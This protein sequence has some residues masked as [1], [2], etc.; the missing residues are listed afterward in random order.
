MIKKISAIVLGLLLINPAYAT[1]FKTFIPAQSTA[2]TP[3]AT[4]Y[5][6]LVQG[7]ATKKVA[8]TSL[9][10]A[11]NNLSDLPSPS[12]ARSNLLL[13]GFAVLTPGTLTN[14]K[15][16]ISDGTTIS[17]T[18]D[19]PVLVNGAL[20][21]PTSG[22]LTNAT[23]LPYSGLASGT[24]TTMAAVIGTGGSLTFSGSGSINA[25]EVKGDANV[26]F[27]DVNQSFTKGQAITPNALGSVTGAT[28]IDASTANDF[29]MS[30]TGN[31]TLSNPTNLKAGQ[32]LN[33]FITYG[34]THTVTLGSEYQSAGGTG[35]LAFSSTNA[36]ED[37]LTCRTPDTTHLVCSLIANV[38]H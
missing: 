25:S 5:Y 34:G 9:L 14:T 30:T 1:D 38:S 4:D 37:V 28:A 8:G 7:G 27:L 22:T 17:C 15:W 35:T 36:E 33:F 2:T 16:C 29:T 26:T 10:Y 24:N 21:T 32:T 6:P 23:G 20:G 11:P 13:G 18:Q 3:G 12:A 19:A 31:I